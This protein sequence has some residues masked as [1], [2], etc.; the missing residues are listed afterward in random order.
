VESKEKFWEGDR[1]ESMQGWASSRELLLP[2]KA[3]VRHTWALVIRSGARSLTGP[4]APPT[5][6]VK[7]IN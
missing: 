5:T 2:V 3:V 4:V 1:G 6:P 7:S